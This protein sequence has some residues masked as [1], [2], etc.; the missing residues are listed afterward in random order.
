MITYV[1]NKCKQAI[2]FDD[3]ETIEIEPIRYRML[4]GKEDWGVLKANSDVYKNLKTQV[5]IY[6]YAE[7]V[8]LDFMTLFNEHIEINVKERMVNK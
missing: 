8:K 5:K 6:T 1:C 4:F 3:I 7:N 2:D